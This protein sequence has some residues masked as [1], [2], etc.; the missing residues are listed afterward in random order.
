VAQLLL[1]LLQLGQRLLQAVVLEQHAGVLRERLEQTQVVV[2]EGLVAA[3]ITCE[4]HADDAVVP[5]QRGQHRVA[6][7]QLG[8][9][10][11]QRYRSAVVRDQDP[12]LR[13]HRRRQRRLL[14]R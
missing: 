4:Q 14:G 7:T 10:S 3:A 9:Q 11:T 2:G 12:G 8:E 13:P 1:Q 6:Q 5:T